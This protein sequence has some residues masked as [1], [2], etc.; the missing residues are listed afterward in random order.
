MIIHPSADMAIIP[1][2]EIVNDLKRQGKEAFFIA[3][4]PSY[5][6]S[7]PEINQLRPVEQ[8]LTVGYPGVIWDDVHNLPVFHSGY[9]ATPAYIDFKGNREFLIDIATWPGS[10]GSPVFL[11]ND[12]GWSD[13]NGNAV[14]GGL[15]LALLGVV[16]GVATQTVEGS[17]VIR[18]APTQVVVPGQIS[19][20]T[21]LGAC[22]KAARIVEL[23]PVLVSMGFKP[24]AGYA[25]KSQ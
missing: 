20:P 24:P 21:N 11:F 10:S 4:D 22:I 14:V 13:R 19:V 18:D 5:M 16:Y 15:R 12:G 1:V 23:E 25:T 6:L 9:T 7:E 2:A 3:I 8:I 17:V